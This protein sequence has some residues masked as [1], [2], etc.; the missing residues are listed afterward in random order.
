MGEV[1]VNRLL[2]F[3]YLACGA[4]L[5][6]CAS[7]PSVNTKTISG[8]PAS[9]VSFNE[10]KRAVRACTGLPNASEMFDNFEAIGYRSPLAPDSTSKTKLPNGKTRIVVPLVVHDAGD[11]IVQ[12][13]E[14]YCYVGL[15]GMTPQQSFNLA[16]ILV[17]KFGATTNAE[18]GQGLSDHAVQAWRVQGSGTPSVLIAAHKTWPWDRG[19][20]PNEEGAAITLVTR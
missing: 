20:W 11:V 10:A 2:L 17:E 1:N 3:F 14:G 5:A 12:A 4:M 18:N 8:V 9:S 16:Q 19:S 7:V 13:G 15:R 6:G